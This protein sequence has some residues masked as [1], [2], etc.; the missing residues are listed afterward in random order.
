LH[1]NSRERFVFV[2]DSNNKIRS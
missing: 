1:G 2:D